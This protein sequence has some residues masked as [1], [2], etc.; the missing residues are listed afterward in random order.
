MTDADGDKADLSFQVYTTDASGNPK[1]QVQLTDPDTGKPAAYGVLVSDYVTSGG[2]ANVTIRYGDLKPNTTYAFRTSAYDGSLYETTWSSWA[3]FHTR[4]R[5]VDIKL[6]EPNKDAAALNQDNFQEPQKIAQPSI[7][8]VPPATPPT[9]LSASS[10]W[11]CGKVNTKTGIQ[12][13]SR[14]V[15]GVSKSARQSLLK[16]ATSGLPHLVDWCETYTDSHIKRY[17]ACISGF[18]YEYEGI[19]VKDGKPTGE[20]LNASWAVGQEVRLSGNSGTFTQQLI[21]VPVE[22]DPKF[23]SVTLDVRFDCLMADDCSNGPQSWDGAL[24]WTGANPFSHNA[25]GK[26]DHTWTPTDNMDL[27]DLSTKIT[28]YSPVANPAA[29]RWQADGAQIRCET[30]ASTT[31]GCTFYK[32]VPTWVMNFAKTPPAVAHAWLI[33]SKLPNHPG[34]RAANKPMFFLPSKDKNAPGRDP[35]DNRKVICPDGWAATYGNPDATTVPEISTGDKASCDEFAYAS[36]YNSG[37]M[38]GG[39]MG[40][41]NEVDTGNDCVQSYATRVKQGEW[42]LY[43]D[44]R[45]AAPTWKEVCGRSAMSG[46]INSTSMGGAFSSGFSGKYR[47]L[48]KDP[49]WVDFPQFTHCDATKATVTCTVPKP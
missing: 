49:Y 32:Y 40:G 19:V 45:T 31:P 15:P 39:T 42:H 1:D 3:K 2:W 17:E 44:I 36:S 43:D 10:G 7:V 30:I 22:V 16:Q 46:W 48:D 28:A 23:I 35:D 27:L 41:L 21:L 20:I 33:Q 37:G 25:I 18:T 11:N 6:P 38:P 5:A 4:G 8:S 12:P 47:L 34:S 9:G 14:I 13:C 26:L 24:E 29:S